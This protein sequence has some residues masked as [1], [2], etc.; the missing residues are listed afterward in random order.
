MSDKTQLVRTA[1]PML[2]SFRRWT[3]MGYETEWQTIPAARPASITLN[4]GGR[5]NEA[6]LLF[7]TLRWHE[8]FDLKAGDLVQITTTAATPITVFVG[9]LTSRRVGFSGG[10]DSGGGFER[11]AAV[12]LDYRWLYNTTSPIFGQVARGVD[13]YTDFGTPQQ[14]PIVNQATLM[15]ARRTIFNP[16]GRANRDP[17][18]LDISNWEQRPGAAQ[19]VPIFCSVDNAAAA[20][21][22][23]RQ[24]IRY[25]LNPYYNRNWEVFPI[26]DPA[27]M[28]GIE[29][30]DFDAVLSGVVCDGLGAIDAVMTVL[31]QIGWSMREDYLGGGAYWVFYKPGAATGTARSADQ[32]TI[33]HE[34]YAPPVGSAITA[35]VAAGKKLCFIGEAVTDA[36][37]VVNNPLGL[38]APDRFEATFELVPAW[39]DSAIPATL[40]PPYVLDADLPDDPDEVEYFR[41]F[42]SRGADFMRDVGRK[43]ALNE[44]GQYS[45]TGTYDRGVPFDFSDVISAAHLTDPVTGRRMYG[46]FARTFLPALSYDAE[47]LNSAG[48]LVELSFD[49]GTTWEPFEG[50]VENLP[51][52]CGIRIAEPNL[53]DILSKHTL[54]A[55]GGGDVN[56]WSSLF[57]DRESGR[58][59][60]GG[61]WLTRV[62]VTATVQMDQRIMYYAEPSGRS[63]SPLH[64]TRV[65]DFTDRYVRS[66]RA[67][68][69]V[70]Y[71]MGLPAFEADESDVLASHLDLLRAVNEDASINGRFVLDRLWVAAADD[72]DAGVPCFR[73][74]DGITQIAGRDYS[75]LASYDGQT[76]VYPEV[77]QII[78][79]I[80]RQAQT[81][82][83]R[84]LRLATN[85]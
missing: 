42:H 25:L 41:K 19:D 74:G 63:G 3:A 62:R 43:W 58:S 21:W 69:S 15:S 28:I 40:D 71:D 64:H 22:T 34:L 5:S 73:V 27:A 39:Q 65:F 47:S 12:C 45:D 10:D 68:S 35:A 2:V 77:V 32:P 13:D 33:L 23:A 70:F 85:L 84:D 51:G 60:K 1:E 4:A 36:A 57:A 20:F 30:T 14:S 38:G 31:D 53:A 44:A 76:P 79:D 72:V 80:E 82:I 48:I 83:T 56:Y 6:T 17:V 54:F 8:D 11:N 24:M 16:D 18:E 67:I 37:A 59:F 7:P 9:F 61:Q 75:L 46:P 49:G 29:H 50:V 66:S 81:L 26:P 55:E 52:E 78:Y